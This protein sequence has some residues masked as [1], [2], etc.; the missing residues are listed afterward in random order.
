MLL[1]KILYAFLVVGI[2]GG[3]LGAALVV[4][5][6]FFSVS[7]D[8]RIQ[9]VE[10]ALPG[11]N[12]GSCGYAG[13][14]AYAE[15]IAAGEAPLTLCGPGGAEAASK[16]AEIMGQEVEISDR[17]MVAQVHCRGTKETT[18][19]LYAYR[20]LKDCNAVHALFQGDKECKYGCLGLGSCMKVCPVDAISYDSGGR[21]VVDKDACI[22]CGNCIEV[23]PTG[24]MQFVPYEADYIVACN[25]KDKGAAVRKYCSVGCIGCK[26]CE[27]K[28]P[29]GGFK[30]EDFLSSIDY[31]KMGDRSEAAK[32]CPPKC[33]VRVDS[34]IKGV[35][36]KA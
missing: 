17:K 13:C 24:V 15:A 25:S 16:I 10:D 8:E 4:A 26:I 20:G 36:E 21:V 18:S 14:A 28:S 5:S 34:L 32:G 11:A 2:L 7:K 27:K 3:V 30:V 35:D 9:Q 6:K 33:I 31:D 12:C 1:L 29:E 23:C 19:Y 22:S